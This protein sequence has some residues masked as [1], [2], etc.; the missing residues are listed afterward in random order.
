MARRKNT[1][2]KIGP[3]PEYLSKEEPLTA[4]TFSDTTLTSEIKEEVVKVQNPAGT[5]P[6]EAPLVSDPDRQGIKERQS[7]ESIEAAIQERLSNR[8]QE[9]NVDPF[10]PSAQLQN[11]VKQVAKLNGFPL[12]RGTEAG[13]ALMARARRR[14]ST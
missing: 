10:V 1:T 13:A 5:E 4:E 12:S 9:G 8:S 2:P 3:A 11:E 14:T 6:K 7:K